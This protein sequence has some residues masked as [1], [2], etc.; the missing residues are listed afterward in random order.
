MRMDSGWWYAM[1]TCRSEKWLVESI[2]GRTFRKIGLALTR[3][4]A[5]ETTRLGFSV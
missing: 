2:R 5:S 4:G 3:E 1:D